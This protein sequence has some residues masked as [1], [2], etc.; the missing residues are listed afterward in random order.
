ATP[1]PVRTSADPS[2]LTHAARRSAARTRSSICRTRSR[3]SVV[4][5][6][7]TRSG[8]ATTAS[9]VAAARPPRS[10]ATCAAALASAKRT[11]AGTPATTDTT[12]HA[13]TIPADGRATTTRTVVPIAAVVVTSHGSRTRRIE[14]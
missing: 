5:P 10:G 8:D 6:Y 1:T 2:P 9:D 4:A 7:A 13:S 12:A 3:T 14:S 11:R